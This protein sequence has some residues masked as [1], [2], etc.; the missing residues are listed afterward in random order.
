[1]GLVI[2]TNINALD[3]L[4][5][6][7]LADNAQSKSIQRLSTGLR[8]NSAAD[9]PSGLVIS[10]VLRGQI[11]SL[12][13]A[14]LN[15]Q[16]ASN[17]VGT[18]DAAL[19]E[20][21]NLLT[22]IR[23]SAMLALNTG[24][25]SPDQIAAEQD[26]V[27]SAI[28]SINR[29]AATTRFGSTNLLNGSSGFNVTSKS[30]E[31]TDLRFRSIAFD[32]QDSITTQIDIMKK[33]ERARIGFQLA[34]G[35]ATGDQVIR[36]SGNLGTQEIFINSGMNT[37]DIVGMINAVRGNTGLFAV[38]STGTMGVPNAS[39]VVAI[40]TEEY[41]SVQKVSLEVISGDD[42]KAALD[43]GAPAAVSAGGKLIASGV[44]IGVNI[45]GAY[46]STNG[47][48]ITVNSPFLN[49]DIKIADGTDVADSPLLFTVAKSGLDFQLNI[50]PLETDKMTVG[51]PNISANYLGAP[52][53]TLGSGSAER[54][55]GGFLNSLISGGPNDLA[56]NPQNAVYIVDAAVDE[57]NSLRGYLGAFASQT[58]D[59][60]INSL[61]VAVENLTASESQIRD[62]D[63]AAEVANY[64][65]AQ[66]LFLAGI[67]V[68][69]SANQIPQSVLKLL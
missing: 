58:L 37:Q 24:G 57:V 15:S 22:G 63:F 43:A 52:V 42:V 31:I 38:L 56:A 47:N 54:D 36:V 62:L 23:S 14:V 35:V 55:V 49:A 9:D 44:D 59:S 48:N 1:M 34:S 66:V 17:L 46:V 40:Q 19:A 33:A 61:G 60:N 20:V 45:A 6:L 11:A 41:G 16:S 21:S 30:T 27:D 7:G 3:A 65:R 68:L 13:Q 67:S 29:I 12:N 53:R 5:N 18:A 39:D 69:A 51:L 8:I 10:E 64:T 32:G 26:A 28:A 25:A 50:M 4:R 2:N